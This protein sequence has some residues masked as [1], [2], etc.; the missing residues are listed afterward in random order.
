MSYVDVIEWL[1][2]EE[3]RRLDNSD[4]T[5]GLGAALRRAGLPI[6]LLVFHIRLAHPE[7][8]GHTSVWAPGRPVE[9]MRRSYGFLESPEYLSSPMR[10]AMES[11]RTL[12]VQREGGNG[13]A[14]TTLDIF[15]G[16]RLTDHVV[17]PL[18]NQDGPSA[19]SFCTTA[20]A[21]FG[22]EHCT[23]IER[24]LPM[25]RDIVELRVLRQTEAVLLD[26]YVGTA[27]AQRILAGNVRRGQIDAL[28]AA[29]MVCDL[30][31]FTALSNRLSSTRI[32]QILDMY[33]D[34]VIPPI[35]QAGGEVL[36]FMGDAV[37]A[38]FTAEAPVAATASASKAALSALTRLAE[39]E[40]P[41]AVIEASIALHYGKVSYG[42]IGS[43][44]RLDFTVIGPD[45]NLLNRIQGVCSDVGKPLLMSRRFSELLHSPRTRS[46]GYR[47]LK[48]F[49]GEIELYEPVPQ[50]FDNDQV[51][52]VSDIL[53]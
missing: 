31:G 46:I 19:V 3:C 47:K 24:I 7:L 12:H 5:A 15:Q 32:L 13:A 37:L 40:L 42:N 49:P 35:I 45:I 2:G 41:D 11:G 20:A 14:W 1:S 22:P 9:V 38:Y 53:S 29:L 6:D 28:E 8:V 44:S 21:G 48:G 50:C 18:N 52:Q 4:F 51:A 27:T 16:H 36:K 34:R 10:R 23:L 26:T 43:G 30:R 33:F 39:T 25:L 17:A